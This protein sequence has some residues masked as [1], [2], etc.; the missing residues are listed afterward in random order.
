MDH[1]FS[2]GLSLGSKKFN[3]LS[4]SLFEAVKR[5]KELLVSLS[6]KFYEFNSFSELQKVFN[7]KINSKTIEGS[8]YL[9][10]F[11]TYTENI[12]LQMEKINISPQTNN[13]LRTD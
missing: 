8:K 2:F 7:S 9:A 13:V 5:L 1:S 4:S 3:E 10:L 12:Y 11:S 6:I